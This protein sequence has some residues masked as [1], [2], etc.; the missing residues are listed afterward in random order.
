MTLGGTQPGRARSQE[1]ARLGVSGLETKVRYG[2]PRR[3][4]GWRGTWNLAELRVPA[5]LYQLAPSGSFWS[6]RPAR[7]GGASCNSH[8]IRWLAASRA[9][10]RSSAYPQALP[11]CGHHAWYPCPGGGCILGYPGVPSVEVSA[12]RVPM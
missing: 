12:Y 10:L 3:F 6:V 8:P 1:G 5:S 4:P 11:A 7:S 2:K 9:V